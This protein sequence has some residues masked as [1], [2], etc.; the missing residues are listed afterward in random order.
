MRVF[1]T[2]IPSISLLYGPRQIG[3][4]ASLKLFLAGVRDC[5]TICF[6][7]CSTYLERRDLYESLDRHIKGKTTVVLDEVQSVDNWHLALR[8]LY[9]EGRL[10]DCRVWCTGSEA[11]YLLESG[12]RL[13]GRKGDGKVVFAKPWSFRKYVSITSP[14]SFNALREID[15]RHITQRWLNELEMDL[16]TLW[17]SY[18]V[19][20][21]FPKSVAQMVKVGAI[22]E[23]TFDTY[24]DWVMGTWS[25]LRTPERS[26]R[27]L[28][29]RLCTTMNSRVSYQALAKGTDIGSP[30]TVRSLLERQEDHFAIRVCS[31]FD[32]N[33][34]AFMPAKQK[35]IYPIDPFIAN[36][37]SLFGDN[38]RRLRMQHLPHPALDECAF[39]AQTLR[40]ENAPETGYLY[41][42]KTK[43]EIDFVFDGYCFELKSKGKPSKAQRAMLQSTPQSFLLTEQTLPV[44]AFL[45]GED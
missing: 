12:E 2:P 45:I 18:L 7:D 26:L 19:C 33:T 9:S 30:N 14:P 20:G 31:R 21:G 4:T 27:Q 44:M 1:E 37:W 15:F 41:A 43:G 35:K 25:H 8:A 13:P 11:R 36:V 40:L 22:D 3:K 16:S 10:S 39:F 6:L 5:E 24:T 34:R 17:Q 29:R 28:A 38:I 32:L 42:P 23:L